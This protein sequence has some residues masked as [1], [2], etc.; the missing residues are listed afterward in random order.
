LYQDDPPVSA[1]RHAGAC[2]DGVSETSELSRALARYENLIPSG[3]YARAFARVIPREGRP[4]TGSYDAR[5]CI[6]AGNVNV[7]I[8][9]Y[10]AR[11][12]I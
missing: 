2:N 12:R 4:L 11:P 8:V 3:Q 7:I 10:P 6:L 5:R 9:R 1:G